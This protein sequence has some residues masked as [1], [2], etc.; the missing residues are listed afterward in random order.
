MADDGGVWVKA[1]QGLSTTGGGIYAKV[2]DDGGKWVEIGASSGSREGAPGAPVITNQGSSVISFNAGE[3]G[4]AGPTLGYGATVEPEGPTLTIDVPDPKVGGEVVLTDTESDTDYVVTIYGVNV[5]GRGKSASTDSFQLNY[6][7]ATGGTETIKDNYNGTTEKWK[8]HTFTSGSQNFDVSLAAKPFSVLVVGGPGSCPAPISGRGSGGG[9]GGAVTQNTNVT[10]TATTYTATVG[11]TSSFAGLT[12]A[13]G[14]NGLAGY[15]AAGYVT[16]GPSGNGNR[17]GY[18][19]SDTLA[20][21]GGGGAGGVGGD[22]YSNG[23]GAGINSTVTGANVSYGRGG[24]GGNQAIPGASGTPGYVIIAYQI[25]MSTTREIAQAEAEAAAREAGYGDG[26]DVGVTDGIVQRNAEIA[27]AAADVKEA[28]EAAV[29]VVE[30]K[31]K[32]TRKK[33]D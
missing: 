33:A 28:V 22:A 6:N 15:T 20:G 21:G 18:N 29:A 1:P 4:A 10:L 5:A 16:G 27:E 23:G 9:G 12:A 17:G 26:Y 25:G 8:V 32:R 30:A 11:G 7:K 19:S 31:P 3:E 14:G 2:A 24:V 13:G